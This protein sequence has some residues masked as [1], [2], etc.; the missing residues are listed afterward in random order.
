MK[1]GEDRDHRAVHGHRDRHLVE[2]DAVEQDLHVVERVDRD[3]RLADIALHARVIAVV[4]AVGGEIEGDRKALLPRGEIAAVKGVRLLGGGEAG[5]LADRPGPAGIH[6]R[7][8]P[9]RERSEAGQAGIDARQ[10]LRRVERLDGD[11]LRR[12][13]GE[14]T[15]L[16]LPGRK[17]LPGVEG[18]PSG[19]CRRKV[20]RGRR[21]AR[22]LAGVDL[23][24]GT[25]AA[26]MLF[27]A[28]GNRRMKFVPC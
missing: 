9:A 17:L 16:D 4:A 26:Q 27:R 21:G 19:G 8:H 18:R 14:I 10:V 13:P 5:I 22:I 7:A 28:A 15:T 24:I 3:A 23:D 2:R 20:A 6:G 25:V 1:K 11:T 12:V